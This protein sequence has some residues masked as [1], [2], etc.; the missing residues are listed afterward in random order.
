M[1]TLIE[2]VQAAGL[3]RHVAV[4]MDGNGRW[5]GLR[6]LPRTAGHRA[7]AAAAEQ[8]IRFAGDRLGLQYL[9]LYAFST[10][11]WQRPEDEVRFLMGLLADFI[12]EKLQEFVARGVRLHTAGELARLPVR[13]RKRVQRAV[14]ETESGR[15]L[16]LTVAL[17]YGGRQELV[18]AFA[19][20]AGDIIEGRLAIQDVDS[21]KIAERLY[22]AGI[23]D[24]DL[25][26][27]TSGEQR[28]SNFLL[29]QAAYAELHFSPVLWPD[30]TPAQFVKAIDE[31]Q[32]RERRF[33][34]V[35]KAG[36]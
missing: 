33:G 23:P 3:P 20:M 24:P 9:T 6:G 1:A 28:L 17:N 27:R 36:A 32:R 30:F 31:F 8:L 29:W 19:A 11:N 5:A 15:G 21:E 7:G 4:I 18:R 13:L 34:S 12:E 10:E 22:T 2:R 35:R 14:K 16:D 26:I 25:I